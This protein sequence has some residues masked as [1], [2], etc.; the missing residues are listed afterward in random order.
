V[1][2]PL[3]ASGDE[4]MMFPGDELLRNDQPVATVTTVD[5][6]HAVQREV[7]TACLKASANIT[8]E[9]IEQAVWTVATRAGTVPVSV[10]TAALYDPKRVRSRS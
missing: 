6:C 1:H 2:A 3:I 10:T 5:P 8:H 7:A 9:W 4:L